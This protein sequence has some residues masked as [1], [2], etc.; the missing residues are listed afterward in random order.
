MNVDTLSIEENQLKDLFESVYKRKILSFETMNS[1]TYIINSENKYLMKL[2]SHSSI[3]LEQLKSILSLCEF[4]Q[5]ILDKSIYQSHIV[6]IDYN[7]Y[8]L[9]KQIG[10]LLAQW[11]LATRTI[12]KSSSKN[13]FNK[14]W[15]NQQYALIVNK[16]KNN[17][18]FLLSNLF[19]CQQQ[20][21]SISADRLETGILWSNSQ[22]SFY[23]MD[24]VSIL[25]IH[26]DSFIH[27]VKEIIDA[28]EEII[29]L[30]DDEINLLDTLVRLQMILLLNDKDTDDENQIV[31]LL[32]QLSSNIFFIRNV[33]R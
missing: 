20:I 3:S 33:V 1:S 32:E 6:L 10:R 27:N 21:S 5:T 23:L 2:F 30:T 19:T 8:L 9:T 25:I 28:Y 18:P 11:R 12:F 17:Y 15:F 14:Q 13:P 26:I 7:N 22:Q 31:D 24:L 29:R 4:N 16:K